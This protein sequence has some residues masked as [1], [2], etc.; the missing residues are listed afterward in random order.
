[1]QDVGMVLNL[2][3]EIPSDASTVSTKLENTC[4][5]NAEP[6]F[7]PHLR[8]LHEDFPKLKIVL[9][10]ATTRAAVEAV[11][12]LGPTV[13]CSITA[14]H[15]ALIVDDW[16]GQAFHFCKPVAK[17][18][19]D[20][21]ALR[22][23][24]R[25]G[26]PRFFLGS[27]SAPHLTN[28]K[29]TSTPSDGCAAG[30]FTSPI[31]LPL[32]AH[33]LESF[34]ALGRLEAFV[35]TNGRTF[36]GLP[37]TGSDEV[38]V[39]KTDSKIV[40]MQFAL[41]QQAVVPFMAGKCLNWEIVS[42]VSATARLA[43]SRKAPPQSTHIDAE[44][45][46]DARTHRAAPRSQRL[47]TRT[48]AP[49]A[50]QANPKATVR[51]KA[52]SRP[53]RPSLLARL[54]GSVM[55]KKNGKQRARVESV[56]EDDPDGGLI[57]I[58]SNLF[59]DDH[60]DGHEGGGWSQGAGN[61]W[62]QGDGN[63]TWGL[64]PGDSASNIHAND[65]GDGNWGGAAPTPPPKQTPMYANSNV[66]SR[67]WGAP[68]AAPSSPAKPVLMHHRQSQDRHGFDNGHG[69]TAAL[70]DLG[71][72]HAQK[73]Q[74]QQQLFQHLQQPQQSP[75]QLQSQHHMQQHQH[76]QQHQQAHPK[77]ER[78]RHSSKHKRT[79]SS[80]DDT[81]GAGGGGG[82]G[83]GGGGWGGDG[84]GA[85]GGGSG[86]GRGAAGGGGRGADGEQLKAEVGLADGG[87]LK[88]EAGP[89]GEAGW[90]AGDNSRRKRGKGANAAAATGGW[91]EAEIPTVTP[92][93]F[94][95]GGGWGTGT[96][97]GWGDNR[98]NN[99][100]QAHAPSI[101]HSQSWGN[102]G[103]DSEAQA[104]QI[105]A[106]PDGK[107][108]KV[109]VTSPSSLFAKTVLSPKQQSRLISGLFGRAFKG[110]RNQKDVQPTPEDN[111]KNRN[112]RKQRFAHQPQNVQVIEEEEEGE[113]YDDDDD[114][115]EEEEEEDSYGKDVGIG[116][117]SAW[118]TEA[119][120]GWDDPA[121]PMPSKA[122]ALAAEGRVPATRHFRSD[123]YN[124]DYR[125]QESQGDAL[126][127]A[128]RAFYSKDRLARNR[129]H[130][131]F[132]PQKDGRVS[133]LLEWIQQVQYQLAT[134]GPGGILIQFSKF[135]QSRERGALFVNADYRPPTSPTEPAFDWL[136]FDEIQPSMDRTLQESL[137]FYE[138]STQ[139][140]VFVFLL[141]KSQN[142]MAIW[143]RKLPLPNNLRLTYGPQ[144]AQATAGLK[145]KYPIHI[146]EV[147]GASPATAAPA[148][149]TAR[150]LSKRKWLRWGPI[151]LPHLCDSILDTTHLLEHDSAA[152][153]S[154]NAA[155][156]P[157]HRHFSNET[158]HSSNSDATSQ[159]PAS[160]LVGLLVVSA[161]LAPFTIL[162]Y[163]ALR[164]HMTRSDAM[165]NKLLSVTATAQREQTSDVS[166]ELKKLGVQLESLQ[167]QADRVAGDVKDV[168][169]IAIKERI[170]ASA[171]ETR[172]EEFSVHLK[173]SEQ[174]II[175]GLAAER[176]RTNKMETEILNA[177]RK[178]ADKTASDLDKVGNSL[179]DIAA[180]IDLTEIEQGVLPERGAESSR[181]IE[182]KL[183]TGDEELVAVPRTA[184]VTERDRDP[185][186]RKHLRSF[187]ND[188]NS[189]PP[190]ALDSITLGQ[191][192]SMV[193]SVPKPKE[194]LYDFRYEDEDTVMNEIEE[195]FSY[196]EAPQFGE[197][198]KA[199][200][201]SFP[202]LPMPR[203]L[204][205]ILQGRKSSEPPLGVF[206]ETS[207]P[208]HQ[209]HWV[210][211]N[212]KTVYAANGISIVMEAIKLANSKHDLLRRVEL[213]SLSDA[214][215]FRFSIS[216]AEKQDC[217]EE[218]NT[219]LSVYFGILYF[220]IEVLKDS[221]DFAEEL[222]RELVSLEP[223]LPV[224]LFSIVAG[225]RDKSFKG[226]PVKKLLLLLWKTILACCGGSRD[227]A[228]VKK[229]AREL[230]NLPEEREEPVPIKSSPFDI[231]T[232]R[233]ETSVKYPTFT[234]PAQPSTSSRLSEYS[235]SRQ[236]ADRNPALPI[237]P[238][239]LAEAFFSY[240][241]QTSLPPWRRLR[242]P[243]I[244]GP[245]FKY[246]SQS[247]RIPVREPY[248]QPESY[249][250]ATH[251]RAHSSA[252]PEAEKAA[253]SKRWERK[254]SGAFAIGEADRLYS[255]H[256]HI[257]VSLLQM[258]RTR[259]ECMI[260]ESGLQRL[261]GAEGK[262]ETF[263]SIL[264]LTSG[265]GNEATSTAGSGFSAAEKRSLDDPEDIPEEL[266]DVALLN[267]KMSEVE[268]AIKQ[269]NRNGNRAEVKKL[270]ELREK[271]EDLM[272]L[273]RI[274]QIY[275]AVLPN[276]SGWVLVLLKMLLA[277]V[278][279]NNLNQPPPPSS[280]SGAFPLV[281]ARQPPP[282]P[283]T[284]DEIDLMRHRE[285]M[286][287]AVSA[288]LLL[289]LKW[290]KASH[291][292]KF[293]YLGQ[294]LLESNCLL[295]ILKMFTLQEV[296]NTV[297]SKADSQENKY[298][299]NPQAQRQEDYMLG[300]RQSSSRLLKGTRE[301]EIELITDFS[302][303]NFF[304]SINFVKIMQKLSK[305]RSHRIWLLVQYKSSAILKRITKVS[306]PM[307]QLY[308][309]KLI[310]SQV[311]YCGR[312]WRQS[313]M[314]VITTIYLNCRP[315][316]RDEWLTG[317]EVDDAQDALAQEQ[318]LRKLVKFY[319]NKRYGAAG[320]HATA[321][322]N[323]RR[324]SS[325]SMPLGEL[326]AGPELSAIA[327]PVG[328]PN[329][330]EAD[331]FPPVRAQ[332]PDPSIFLPYTTEDIAFEE[333]YEEYLSDL[334]MSDDYS[335][336]EGALFGGTSAW[337]RLPHIGPEIADGISDSESIASIGELGDD[338]KFD[339][340]I[341]DSDR[342][343][344][345][346]NRN[347]WEHMSPKTMAALPKSPVG[348]HRRSSSG[349]SLRPV[350]PFGLDDNSAVDLEEGDEDEPEMGPIPREHS[351]PF[352][353]GG[354]VDEV[355]YAYGL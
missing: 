122:F 244:S 18:P 227:L 166:R 3:G 210:I 66:N 2:H 273:K 62:G 170:R 198:L 1:M 236:T 270:K 29:S 144:I 231:Q 35:S 90:G 323:H 92:G 310:K 302:W 350:L 355:E 247:T 307:L 269:V 167:W 67:G 250:T 65:E 111:T 128:Q 103:A 172:S 68:P 245:S 184:S 258:W 353:Q 40:G 290:F 155:E 120:N 43:S 213:I 71:A 325:M 326:H 239:K 199:W 171:L 158:L 160:P 98:A 83:W 206:A 150:T 317:S 23:V 82:D 183:S 177:L 262:F 324:S 60:G 200:E 306:H 260:V 215:A 78:G 28:A 254:S 45:F 354:G 126:R 7:L 205:Y 349:S 165:L 352:G 296:S 303:R 93:G 327:R 293:H 189:A 168:R 185:I 292:M 249:S 216:P 94:G 193:N 313:N 233:Q 208:E 230:T 24:I 275:S 204:F 114:D 191:L 129:I 149:N 47:R 180:F 151:N 139:V 318:A 37:P 336:S 274:E 141:S 256:M 159:R 108:P 173:A 14:H 27:D 104:E 304:S 72:L 240:T 277:T 119:T 341:V 187:N 97:T 246:E 176:T 272:R 175:A 142:S 334:G 311:P 288:I 283:P 106:L 222:K 281:S 211:E 342:E 96:N 347:N 74:M 116:N 300:P 91:G 36:Y 316:L 30:V 181:R 344:I 95:A 319:N 329:M 115:D 237:S 156:A 286:S 15:L 31:L 8:S 137:A 179:A 252:V 280:S 16:A 343:S 282:P 64:A 55:G 127:F 242:F 305:H 228:R 84:W 117:D 70:G 135:L 248:L 25:E 257:S 86:D 105:G 140:L 164:R 322:D 169:S 163:F 278:S 130:W 153:N 109:T 328:T 335:A 44:S 259:E 50:A 214:D 351:G 197:N 145:K 75:S 85:A 291:A 113:Y 57:G 348:G 268:D 146:D 80:A 178:T 49:V 338:A 224:Y 100:A 217:I 53:A 21:E 161:L 42:K 63:D 255:K 331:V 243:T 289:T 346:E 308:V 157:S 121:H 261:A 154:N 263:D 77:A 11:K 5:L 143:R 196:I 89:A 232:F 207:S 56:H 284:L 162:P 201:G 297:V 330:V 264:S 101:T 295:L 34:G 99:D 131:L 235:A 190:G 271:K 345:D 285:I 133:M 234:S 182:Q 138:P 219:E 267:A 52:A 314:K 87:Q 152:F 309:L 315:D 61:G 203:R 32:A 301:E 299:R 79:P 107:T 174:N 6:K 220:L 332:A 226:Y 48:A 251:A 59:V 88:A 298:S 221:D 266:P 265:G 76:Q 148:T 229:L 188:N 17:Y 218:V 118:F 195:F 123:D 26:H 51:L 209:L 110:G 125:F 321:R 132:D 312:K 54:Q 10:H 81:W 134:F 22:E 147:P 19:D 41:G 20:R 202:G 124:K 287:K 192:K 340:G 212:C 276:L 223:P 102:W 69:I 73:A 253:P 337:H 238:L 136:T 186:A 33:L 320:A 279:V 39:R 38:V 58:G 339:P 13:G 294:L 333:E 46:D 9:E 194:Q 241:R 4:V 112:N 12:A 225:L